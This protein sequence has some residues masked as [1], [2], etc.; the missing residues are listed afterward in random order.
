MLVVPHFTG[1]NNNIM[2]LDSDESIND[3]ERDVFRCVNNI[4][5]RRVE[6]YNS[7]PDPPAIAIFTMLVVSISSKLNRKINGPMDK[8]N[9][10]EL[11][12]I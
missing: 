8:L 3:L 2:L 5:G 1:Q 6:I 11:S 10:S 7:L 9:V 12:V 4:S